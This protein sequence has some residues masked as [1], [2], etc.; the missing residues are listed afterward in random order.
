[1]T[2]PLMDYSQHGQALVIEQMITED[3]PRVFIDVGA[4]DGLTGSNSRRLLEQGWRGVLIE[5]VPAVFS[6]LERNCSGFEMATLV[7]AAC[8]DHRGTAR[9]RIGRDGACGQLS[10]LSSHPVIAEN[11]TQESIEVN[12]TTLPDVISEYRIP[13]DFGVLLVDTEGWDLTVLRTLE[14]TSVRPRI[15]VTEE[16]AATDREKYAFL[17]QLKYRF[18]GT[19]GSDSLWIRQDHPADITSLRLPIRRLPDHWIPPG[20]LVGGGQTFIDYNPS[21]G[22]CMAGWACRPTGGSLEQN[23]AILLQKVD[24]PQRYGFL[25]WRVPRQD[26]ADYLKSPDLLMAGYRAPLDIPQGEY[27]VRII[28]FGNGVHTNDAA[29][30]LSFRESEIRQVPHQPAAAGVRSTLGD[31]LSRLFNTS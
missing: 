6:R 1:V 12:T 14:G 13:Q 26:V 20:N 11:L 22:S 21:F 18:A 4:H 28:Q 23:V 25:A 30:R 17:S 15:I 29:G 31:S 19:W 24:S 9:I 5:P 8:S 10:S 2:E 3:T 27:E 16:F 7:Q